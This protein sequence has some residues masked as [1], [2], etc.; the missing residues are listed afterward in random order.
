MRYSAH[1][2]VS[3]KLSVALLSEDGQ[4]FNEHLQVKPFWPI[5]HDTFGITL[6][7]QPSSRSFQPHRWRIR[8]IEEP[9]IWP[10]DADASGKLSWRWS[11]NGIATDMNKPS[12]SHVSCWRISNVSDCAL[13]PY[14]TVQLQWID[15]SNALDHELR[16]GGIDLSGHQL[17]LSNRRVSSRL[18]AINAPLEE[19]QIGEGTNGSQYD[20][21]K[22]PP[23]GTQL[24]PFGAKTL[25][26]QLVVFL[27]LGFK[28]FERGFWY[29]QFEDKGRRGNGL[30]VIGAICI[31]Y[32]GLCLASLIV[33]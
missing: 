21:A 15:Q 11:R 30:T 17:R 19:Q 25:T 1:F 23:S 6:A 20:D 3:T 4:V 2:P 16:G 24:L 10:E 22:H 31:A 28:L 7:P 26:L 18:T 5:W 27:S 29:V 13:H 9:P 12:R 14:P 33:K 32:G 8:T